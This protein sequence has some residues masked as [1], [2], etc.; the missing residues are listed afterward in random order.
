MALS[1][2]ASEA[3]KRVVQKRDPAQGDMAN[4]VD[5]TKP[6][7]AGGY[8]MDGEA[9]SADPF[10]GEARTWNECIYLDT[11]H[12]NNQCKKFHIWCKES[13]CPKKF[14]TFK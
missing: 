7:P 8:I 1:S 11:S 14:M 13:K 10:S 9:K 12:G 3:K 4:F 2:L 5:G 6:R